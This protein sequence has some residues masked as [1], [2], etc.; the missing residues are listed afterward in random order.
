MNL[1]PR[2]A[3]TYQLGRAAGRETTLRT[4]WGVVFDELT[5]PGLRAFG[6]GY[7]YGTT[8]RRTVPP[9]PIPDDVLASRDVFPAPFETGSVG[10]DSTRLRARSAFPTHVRVARGRRS[11]R[12]VAAGKWSMTYAGSVGRDLIYRHEYFYAGSAH[13]IHAYT[14]AATSDYHALLVNYTTAAITRAG[15]PA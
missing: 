15:G 4:G 14:N 7:P 5:S 9:F 1:A 11:G 10:E 13:R 3:L 12:S 8:A 6:N 2:L